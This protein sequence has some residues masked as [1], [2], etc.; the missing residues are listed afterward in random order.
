MSHAIQYLLGGG[1]K[2]PALL[3]SEQR[4]VTHVPAFHHIS[5]ST[6]EHCWIGVAENLSQ[7]L[8]CK[9]LTLPSLEWDGLQDACTHYR[10]SEAAHRGDE[11]GQHW[12]TG[13]LVMCRPCPCVPIS[14]RS[15]FPLSFCFLGEA[16]AGSIH[17]AALILD[18]Y[19]P[20]LEGGRVLHRAS[21]RS[22]I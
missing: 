18:Q 2:R 16:V 8:T 3:G 21:T 19:I 22:Q 13:M 10:L 4:A 6:V 5:F 14:G 1:E 12:G 20:G 11:Q 7:Q 15:R 17:L 9:A